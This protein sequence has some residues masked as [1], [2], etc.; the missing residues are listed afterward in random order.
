MQP[1]PRSTASGAPDADAKAGRFPALR[2]VVLGVAL[3]LFAFLWFD[4]RDY[5][6][7]DA[8]ITFRYS[9]NFARGLGPVYNALERVE[10]YTSFLWMGV[11][12]IPLAIASVSSALASYKAFALFASC[13]VL[14][15]V[16]RFPSPDGRTRNRWLVV[17][18]ASQPVFVLNCGDGMETPLLV[19]LMVELVLVMQR[20][21]TRG[22]GALCGFG[23]AA[24]VW[25]RPESLPLVLAV[26]GLIAL[27]HWG[28]DGL[29]EWCLAFGGAALLPIVGHEL[30]RLSYYGAPWPN[31]FYAKATGD[32]IARLAR[33]GTDLGRFFGPNPWSPP[34]ALWVMSALAL[35]GTWFARSSLRARSS[36]VITWFGALWLMVL[37]RVSFDLWSGSDTMGRHRFVA[38]AIVPLA[39]LADA[40]ARALWRGPWR[41]VVGSALLLAIAFN[42]S[43]HAV[44]VETTRPYAR[45]LERAHIA[46]GRWLH[47]TQPA[48]AVLAIADAGAVPFFSRLET[49][50]LWGLNDAAIARMPGEYGE[51]PGM[52][53]YVMQRGPDLVVLW[54]QRPFLEREPGGGAPRGRVI[55]GQPLDRAIASDPQFRSRYRF[56][57]E[58]VFREFREERADYPGYYLDVFEKRSPGAPR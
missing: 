27:A 9:L 35:A 8:F 7:D 19:L 51:R 41:F 37:F 5:W 3:L 4:Y 28:R 20:L 39:V 17:V 16:A 23:V 53:D 50:D 31:T 11:A 54:N 56:R 44:H 24:L 52:V 34:V 57:R 10:G 45:G 22:T 33:G 6:L 40:G 55:G 13:W 12:A 25:T 2:T 32:L 48:D 18:L 30:F 38:P 15:R 49:I 14:F 58:F 43:G 47:E 46:L 21:P 29:R 1:A 36:A 42:V 26:P